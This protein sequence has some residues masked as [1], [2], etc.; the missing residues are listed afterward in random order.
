[1]R[2]F[3]YNFGLK[4][5]YLYTATEAPLSFY[6]VDD[7]VNSKFEQFRL[8]IAM[9]PQRQAMCCSAAVSLQ[10]R[11]TLLD[12]FEFGFGCIANNSV[13]LDYGDHNVK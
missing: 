2:F 11:F 12:I 9:F 8:V 10:R 5:L 1:M 7:V 4:C 6:G 3:F 13:V